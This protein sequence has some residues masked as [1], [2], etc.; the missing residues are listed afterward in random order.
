MMAYY[1][2]S[3]EA[4]LQCPDELPQG[5]PLLG[6][7]GVGRTA[8][9]VEPALVAHAYAVPVVVL[10]MG[11]RLRRRSPWLHGAVAAYYIVI[12]YALPAPLFV[13]SV[14]VVNRALLPGSDSRA[15]NDDKG[16]CPHSYVIGGQALF[17]T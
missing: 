9:L 4:C 12:A 1:K 5:A 3:G 13:P 16:D 15:V 8:G 10:A 7:A 11:T 14:D 2:G 17:Y 6:R